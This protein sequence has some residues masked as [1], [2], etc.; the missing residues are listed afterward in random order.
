LSVHQ[1]CNINLSKQKI[2]TL[3]YHCTELETLALKL[4]LYMKKIFVYL[5][6]A[7]TI[8]SCSKVGEDEFL[9]KGTIDGIPDGKMVILEKF[10]DSLGIISVDTTHIK[11][12]KF[13]FKGNILEPEMH[14]VKVE[15]AQNGSYVILENGE[16]NLEIVKD[17]TFK[18]KMSGTYNNDQFYEFNQ[19]S[20][21]NE[22]KKK[23]FSKYN[24]TKF[25]DAQKI[26]DSATMKSIQAA[27]EKMEKD[28]QKE[29][30]EYIKSHPKSIISAL[31]TKSFFNEFEPNISKIE[32]L[33]NSLD[34]SIKNTKIG[35]SILKNL[36]DFKRVDVGKRAPEFSAPNPDGKIIS[37][38]ESLGKVT[39][40][41]F[42]ASWCAPCR[43]ENPNM[44]KIYNEFHDKGLNIIGVSLDKEASKWKAAIST[45]KLTWTHVS[46]LKQW[47][48]P[49]AAQYGV[50]SIPK[51]FILNQY[52]IVVAKDLSGES[53]KIKIKELLM[54]K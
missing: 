11:S 46:N 51:T 53:L 39:I 50:N 4:N 9:L 2:S 22:Q 41:D 14:L 8:I 32:A 25:L 5:L 48:D 3:I 12:G 38:K 7:A 36:N 44:V 16:I 13:S 34:E 19:K 29:A 20:L 10:D 24:Q 47:D 35:N 40:I 43:K 30:E 28:I 27:Y 26:N 21:K 42:W 45:D 37:L 49:I 6:F 18:N 17:S 33:F 31:L 54:M 52:G 15:D 23:D 1:L